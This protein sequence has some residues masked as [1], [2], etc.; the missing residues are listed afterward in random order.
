MKYRINHLLHSSWN[1]A[2]LFHSEMAKLHSASAREIT[3]PFTR[4]IIS[5]LLEKA[6]NNLLIIC[7]IKSVL[8]FQDSY[9]RNGD[10]TTFLGLLLRPH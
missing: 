6:C 10:M 8:I 7:L 1:M 3:S 5:E 4:E 9:M 2:M